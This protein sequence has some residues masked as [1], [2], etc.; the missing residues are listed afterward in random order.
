MIDIDNFFNIQLTDIINGVEFTRP[1]HGMAH[2]V[3][4]AMIA[5]LYSLIILKYNYVSTY[6]YKEEN[7]CDI[8]IINDIR[9][10]D[11]KKIYDIEM[12]NEWRELLIKEPEIILKTSIAI[13]YFISGRKSEQSTK[14]TNDPNYPKEFNK[15]FIIYDN[16]N[17]I[18]HYDVDVDENKEL[19]FKFYNDENKTEEKILD[20]DGH[21]YKEKVEIIMDLMYSRKAYAKYSAENFKSYCSYKKDLF[22]EEEIEMYYEIIGKNYNEVTM[23]DTKERKYSIKYRLV[24][25]LIKCS[26][27]MDMVRVA[28]TIHFLDI[29][30]LTNKRNSELKNMLNLSIYLCNITGTTTTINKYKYIVSEDDITT[31]N[32]GYKNVEV[33]NEKSLLYNTDPEYCV[34]Y[35]SKN[36]EQV[37]KNL[38]ADVEFENMTEHKKINSR[39]NIEEQQQRLRK[40]MLKLEKN[41]MNN[42]IYK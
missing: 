5:Y 31:L 34:T 37:I 21:E 6:R 8:P 16:Q 38:L 13:L 9:T 28:E 18:I 42:L 29:P 11:K 32:I 1:N 23:E 22:T 14:G 17:Q 35:I 41:R 36:M 27:M 26:H 25:Y 10:V 33:N 40:I 7:K 3:R 39:T 30:V 19:N 4:S 2:I 12:L 24:L 15:K 20:K